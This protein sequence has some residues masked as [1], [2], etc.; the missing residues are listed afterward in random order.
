MILS[1]VSLNLPVSQGSPA[2]TL[3]TVGSVVASLVERLPVSGTKMPLEFQQVLLLPRDAVDQP[4]QPQL[5]RDL[6]E[7][8]LVPDVVAHAGLVDDHAE[9]RQRERIGP[10]N[11]SKK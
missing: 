3:A 11:L 4:E 1:N 10:G 6:E 9:P 2:V 5:V 7:V 8:G